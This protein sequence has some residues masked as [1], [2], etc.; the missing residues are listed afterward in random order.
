MR[1]TRRRA[2][3]A[4]GA[5]AAAGAAAWTWPEQGF[6]NPCLGDLP[7][8]LALHPL[9]RQAFD[10]LDAALVLDAH[11]HVFGVGDAGDDGVS[12]DGGRGT[13]RWPIGALQRPALENAA[14]TRRG[15][16]DESYVERLTAL[17]DALPVGA[18]C[19][20]LALDRWHDDAGRPDRSRTHVH[21]ANDY[22]ARLAAS[23]PDRFAWAASV[24][25]ARPD[26][27]AE[28]ERARR[29]G[30]RAVKWIPSAQNIDPSSARCDA[31]YD[32][33]VRLRLPL[34]AH[35]GTQ[36]AAPGDD[37]LGNPLRLRRPLER[38][39]TVVVAHCAS[40]GSSPDL[41]RGPAGPEVANFALFERLMDEPAH[42]GRLF[43]DLSALTQSARAPAALDRVLV[44]GAEGGEWAARLVNG[45][46]YPLPAILPLT[47]PRALAQS[48]WLDADAVEPLTELRRHNAL[49]FDFVL[50]RH[51]HAGG[52]RLAHA[53]FEGA[54]LFAPA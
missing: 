8:G 1:W 24:H 16:M 45:S 39:V 20:V 19:L 53:V 25:P 31:F 9:V 37:A 32:A 22:A 30:A 18:R 49:L 29:L 26:A 46:D 5:L 15:A 50:K 23:R 52:R 43:G 21:V 27:Q 47:S 28:L 13:L 44:R 36:R 11:V 34:I 51:L 2:I 12:Y 7:R 3:A 48:G 42:V 35:A 33:L 41:D 54:R 17:A 6:V 10:G 38:G 14:C 40:M 4:G